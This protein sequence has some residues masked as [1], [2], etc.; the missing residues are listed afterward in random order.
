[1]TF[2]SLDYKVF[3]GFYATSWSNYNS[4][5]IFRAGL[6]QY[7]KSPCSAQVVLHLLDHPGLTSP[8]ARPHANPTA[9]ESK[10][11]NLALLDASTG[12]SKIPIFLSTSWSHYIGLVFYFSLFISEIFLEIFPEM[13]SPCV[14]Q[15]GLN[16]LP[17][18]H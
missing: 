11:W 14:A 9:R 13:R 16:S 4:Y 6:P 10:K 18:P 3:V 12:H 17:Q 5:L 8:S 7:V 2:T 1:M 15:R